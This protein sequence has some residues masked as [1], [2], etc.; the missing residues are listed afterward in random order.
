M[1]KAKALTFSWL[2][3]VFVSMAARAADFVPGARMYI[4]KANAGFDSQLRAAIVKEHV[5]LIVVGDPIQADFLMQGAYQ[6]HGGASAAAVG[7]VFVS[8][9]YLAVDMSIY[10]VDTLTRQQVFAYSVSKSAR[11]SMQSAAEAVAKQLG[12]QLKANGKADMAKQSKA[13][14]SPSAVAQP[15]PAPAALPYLDYNREQMAANMTAAKASP[16]AA[17]A[18]ADAGRQFSREELVELI[19]KGQASKFAVVTQPPGAEVYLDGNRAATTPFAGVL[20]RHGDTPRIITVKMAGYK[21]VE[22][23]VLPDGK[24]IPISIKLEKE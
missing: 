23:K 22:N 9:T 6:S 14:A 17:A 19:Q 1:M 2:L 4:P 10:V 8:G 24:L 20:A 11:H 5:P 15:T 16:A 3:L 18:L 13:S 12:E 21:T 7:S